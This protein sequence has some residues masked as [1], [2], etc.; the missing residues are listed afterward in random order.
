MK[1]LLLRSV[2]ALVTGVALTAIASASA[3]AGTGVPA[4]HPL[5]MPNVNNIH[6]P[7]LQPPPVCC[8]PVAPPVAGEPAPVNMAYFGGH[9]QVTPKIYVVYWGWGQAGAFDHTTPGMP[10]NDP[11]GAAAR[12]TDFVQAMG[13]TA[14]A[15]VSTQYYETVGGT[16]VYIENPTNVFGGVWY[17]DTNPIHDNVTGLELAQEAQRAVAHFGV[18]DLKNSQ[19]V[20]AQPQKF[21][22]AGFNAGVGY[23]AWHDYTQ[24]QYYPGVQAGIS[25]TNMPYS[26]NMSQSCGQNSVNSG[27]YAGKLDGFT[28]V[29][30]HEV[31]ET[32]T[33]PGAEDVINGQNLGGW[34]DY[35]AYEN[36]DKCAWVGY[37]EGI[38]PPSS[39]PG[40]LNNITG[41]D[42]KQ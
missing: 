13:G 12:M 19:F 6:N 26:L 27:Y 8:A 20:I 9:V 40:G 33:D 2:A 4:H 25:F 5:Y 30:G 10:A 7:A 3:F 36:G 1:S 23:C 24:P 16:N 38:A 21:N 31:E 17:D 42:G 29:L 14:W 18:T 28:I 34:Y 22:E 41:N 15:G 39:V 11:D 37:L 35:S 32:I